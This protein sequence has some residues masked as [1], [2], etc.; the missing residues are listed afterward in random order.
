VAPTVASGPISS[1][2]IDLQPKREVFDA[3]KAASEHHDR[4]ACLFCKAEI[5]S[6]PAREGA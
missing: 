2:G 1:L 4:R 6:R 3:E 5:L